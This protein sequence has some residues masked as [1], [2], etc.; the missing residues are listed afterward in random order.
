MVTHPVSTESHQGC[1]KC[2]QLNHGAWHHPLNL[3][4][5][6]ACGPGHVTQQPPCAN[7]YR[8]VLGGCLPCETDP[9][10]Q[11]TSE[12]ED[13]RCKKTLMDLGTAWADRRVRGCHWKKGLGSG[14]AMPLLCRATKCIGSYCPHLENEGYSIYCLSF[15]N[16]IINDINKRNTVLR[17]LPRGPED[18]PG[19][20]G[21]CLWGGPGAPPGFLVLRRGSPILGSAQLRFL[22]GP[23]RLSIPS[24]G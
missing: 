14:P 13:R 2:Q 15:K 21:S 20:A 19:P 16:I 10:V 3:K 1:Q 6:E 24:G 17:G 23:Q 7:P 8:G 9:S 11:G 22:G 5:L 12:P 4:M 18:V